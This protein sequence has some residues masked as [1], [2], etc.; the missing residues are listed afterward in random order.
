MKE[1]KQNENLREQINYNILKVKEGEH[2]HPK[3][4]KLKVNKT[5]IT[6]YLDDKREISIPIS[7]LVRK[8]NKPNLTTEQLKEY[9]IDPIVGFRLHFPKA[10][11]DTSVLIFAGNYCGCC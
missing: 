8:W 3:L 2:F 11:I 4:L 7:E 6:A 5:K 1:I 9:E 10:D